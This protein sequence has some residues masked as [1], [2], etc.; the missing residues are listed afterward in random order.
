M[1]RLDDVAATVV[2]EGTMLTVSGWGTTSENSGLSDQ[3][4]KVDVPIVGRDQCNLAYQGFVGQSMICAGF[5]SGG[6]DACNGDSGGPLFY[7]NDNN[8]FI[9]GG[10]VSWGAGCSR[11]GFP[12]VYTEVADYRDWVCGITNASSACFVTSPT[13]P[14][15]PPRSP[16]L[17]PVIE[18]PSSP[19]PVNPI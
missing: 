6:Q 17:S 2:K 4:L 11:P 9:V 19:P 12:G 8:D 3:A 5:E 7:L 1:W 15:A 13:M 10:V 18:S 16:P 14:P